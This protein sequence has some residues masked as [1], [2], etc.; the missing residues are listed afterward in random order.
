MYISD[1]LSLLRKMIAVPS[2]SFHETEV[3]DLISAHLTEWGIRHDTPKNNILAFNKNYSPSLP[4]L[5]LD[6][7]IDTVPPAESYTRNPHDPGNDPDTI[8]GLGANDDGGSVVSMIAA[9]RHFYDKELPI[10]IVLSLNAEEEKSGPDGARWIYSDEGPFAGHQPEWVIIGEPTGMRAATSERGLLVLDAEAVGVS[11]HAA[12]NEGVNALYIALEDICR[13][14]QYAFD[15]ISPVMGAVK[16]NVT[17]ISAGTAHNVIPDSC[18]FV[19]DIRPTEQYTNE[20]IVSLLQAQCKSRLT[21]R[22]LTNRSSATPPSS[23]L[24]KVVQELGI[25][26]FSSPTTSNWMRTRSEAI[27]MGP[28]D[29]ARSHRADEYIHTSEITQAVQGYI[30]F[31]KQLITPPLNL[32]LKG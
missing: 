5:V 2:L 17:Q 9:F 32:P 1:S 23:L 14:R 22:N 19:V 21:P 11:G 27:K 16:L 3:R 15:R 28:G 4:T 26:T 18:R 7:H 10:N 24:L 30:N 8:Y 20:E 13:L 12:R 25:P 31:V 29:S 6:A